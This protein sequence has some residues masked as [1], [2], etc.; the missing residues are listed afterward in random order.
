[1]RGLRERFRPRLPG[2]AAAPAPSPGRAAGA[3]P[4]SPPGDPRGRKLAAWVLEGRQ[5]EGCVYGSRRVPPPSPV[6][7][8]FP[9][10]NVLILFPSSSA[11]SSPLHIGKSLKTLM[12]KGILQVHP[13]ICDCPGCRISSPVVRL[14]LNYVL[15][16]RHLPSPLPPSLKK[17]G[18]KIPLLL[19]WWSR[20]L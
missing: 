14:L 5:G 1:M 20:D 3:V 13:P 12:S 17:K 10:I 16:L 4:G 6:P 8:Y 19:C 2:A 15:W 7:K 11:F 9:F 18:E